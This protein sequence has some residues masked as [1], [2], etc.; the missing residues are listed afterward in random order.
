MKKIFIILLIAAMLCITACNKKL[1][2]DTSNLSDLESIDIQIN[3]SI[4][5]SDETLSTNSESSLPSNT[6]DIYSSSENITSSDTTSTDNTTSTTTDVIPRPEKV[7]KIYDFNVNTTVAEPIKQIFK[8]QQNGNALPYCLYLPDNYSPNK[9]YPVILFLHGAGEIGS[10]NSLQ[11]NNIKNM[12]TYNADYISQ[13]ILLCPQTPEWWSF[14]RDYYEDGKGTLSS[15]IN[16][17]KEIQNKYSCDKNRIYLTGLSMGSFATWDVLERYGDMFAAAVP[18]CGGGNEMNASAYVDIPIVMY[19]GTADPTVSFQSS[20]RTYDAIVAAGGTKALLIP[21][22]GVGHDAWKQAYADR[23]MFAWLFAQDKSKNTFIKYQPTSAFRIVDS[24]GNNVITDDD[25]Q[26]LDYLENPDGVDI[27]IWLKES[28]KSKLEKAYT[29]SGGQEFTVYCL[30]QKIYSFTATV[31]PVDKMFL[32]SGVF[33]NTNYREFY[34]T[35][36]SACFAN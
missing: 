30:S 23:N 6:T 25:V 33:D 24:K 28:G 3:S 31:A 13:A 11:L 22:E 36:Q 12:F 16:L 35:V 21:L 4:V 8:D 27:K 7:T 20:Q 19:H 5:S 1:G 14:D 10:D 15:A 18:V 26:V 32:I 29:G 34:D 9:K 17:L 2:A